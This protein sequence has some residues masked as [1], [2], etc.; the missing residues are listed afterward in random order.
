[1]PSNQQAS[2]DANDGE[3]PEHSDKH[4]LKNGLHGDELVG[5]RHGGSLVV[6][7]GSRTEIVLGNGMVCEMQLAWVTCRGFTGNSEGKN[8]RMHTFQVLR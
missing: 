8:R 4:P 3:H 2:N 5:G 6:V 1:M 7:V